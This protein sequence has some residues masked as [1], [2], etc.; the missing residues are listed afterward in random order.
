M[1][2][3]RSPCTDLTPES[4]SGFSNLWSIVEKPFIQSINKYG[5]NGSP[6]RKPRPDKIGPISLRA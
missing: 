3:A 4:V 1:G 6:W 5:D 2:D